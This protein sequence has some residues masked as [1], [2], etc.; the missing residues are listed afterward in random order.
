M[1]Y[2]NMA[3]LDDA[4]ISKML[5]ELEGLARPNG[6]SPPPNTSSNVINYS[7]TYQA[8]LRGVWHSSGGFNISDPRPNGHKGHQ[9][10]DMRAYAGTPVYPLTP[11]I[12]IS[13]GTDPMGGNVVNIQ[14]P[15]G[16][17]TYYAHLSTVKV[18]KNDKV[19]QN[20]VIGSVG[21]TGNAAHTFP[22]LHFQVWQNG[23]ISDP[24]K[25]FPVPKYSN[26]SNEEKQHGQWLS[27]QSR[28]DATTF[29][30]QNHIKRKSLAFTHRAN[31]L[32]K[33]SNQYYKLTIYPTSNYRNID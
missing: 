15:N 3:Q 10:L 22:H 13:V 26:L 25:F 12:V 11:G 24:A 1:S 17:R 6:A 7:G 8:P 18:H 19:D 5:Q 9:G 32:L 30:M 20:T 14:H 33:L 16:I 21:N 23:Q 2:Y 29:N 28:Q 4:Y 27:E 31:I